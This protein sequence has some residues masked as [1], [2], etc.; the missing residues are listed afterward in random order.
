M[1]M[2]AAEKMQKYRQAMK[3]DEQ[4]YKQYLEKEKMRFTDVYIAFGCT[5]RFCRTCSD[6]SGCLPVTQLMF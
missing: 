4:T 6:K 3:E 1:G 2:S 5:A